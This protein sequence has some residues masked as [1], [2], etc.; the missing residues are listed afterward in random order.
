[1]KGPVACGIVNSDALKNYVAGE[2]IDDTV[3]TATTP[4]HYVEIIGWG[5]DL[6]KTV[7]TP[8]WKVRN[9]WGHNWGDEGF[10]KIIRGKNNLLIDDS[11][12]FVVPIDTWTADSDMW[13]FTSDTE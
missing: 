3:S 12:S 8:Y 2:V 9:S 7:F 4:D 1:M 10:F 11:C 6:V 5:V 13:H